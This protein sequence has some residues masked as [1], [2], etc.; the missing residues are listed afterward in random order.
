LRTRSTSRPTRPKA[1]GWRLLFLAGAC[2]LIATAAWAGGGPGFNQARDLRISRQLAPQALAC[3]QCHRRVSPALF[4]QWAASAHAKAGVTCHDC[5]ISDETGPMVSRAHFDNY[6][7]GGALPGSALKNR[8]AV[9]AVVTPKACARCHPDQARQFAKSKHAGTLQILAQGYSNTSIVRPGSPEEA[10][11]CAACHG[12]QVKFKDGAPLADTW[13]NAGVGRINPDGSRGACSSC[14]SR[15]LFSKAEARKPEACAQCHSGPVHSQAEIYGESKHGS[16]YLSQGSGWQWNLA[17]LAW[18]AGAGYR[19]PTCASCHI[20]GVGG[21]LLSNH[22]VSARLSWEL[23]TPLSIRPEKFSPW[24][25][26]RSWRKARAEM[27]TVCLQCHGAV[28]V[29]QHYQRLDAAVAEYN[30]LYFK[31]A[32]AKLKKNTPGEKKRQQVFL[33]LW[34]RHGRYARMGAAMMA[35]DF[36]WWHGFYECKKDLVKLR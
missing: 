34:H 20:S 13:P 24:P 4:A 9:T 19:A 33:D 32:L 2:L 30:D 27:R 10:R 31:P 16:I 23:Q 6:K 18:R 29:D 21:S 11:L 28:W 14:H 7:E 12:S 36:S 26:S 15:H 25:A 35:P 17:P 5:H 3:L 1:H 22:N 8:L